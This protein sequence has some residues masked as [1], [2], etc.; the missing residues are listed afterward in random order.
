MRSKSSN[1]GCR[2]E[3]G[4]FPI[5]YYVLLNLVKYWCHMVKTVGQTNSI[6]F[7]AF[8]LSENMASSCNDSWCGCIKEFFKNLKLECLKKKCI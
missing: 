3:L 2:S 6:S 7:E 5:L 1:D 8:K 4:S